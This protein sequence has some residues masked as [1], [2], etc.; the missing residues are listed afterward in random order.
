MFEHSK[1][2]T[3]P[4]SNHTLTGDVRAH[5]AFHSSDLPY[6]RT[7]VVYQPAHYAIHAVSDDARQTLD[8]M[9]S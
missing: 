8:R 3:E 4:A 6:D 9:K 1:P 7:V 5:E 2:A